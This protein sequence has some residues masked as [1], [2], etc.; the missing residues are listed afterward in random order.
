VEI[1]AGSR[2]VPGRKPVARDSNSYNNNNNSL[3]THSCAGFTAPVPI[4]KPA[5]NTTIQHK[6]SR[7][8]QKQNTKQT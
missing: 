8:T 5:K 1:T 2:E 6:N 3:G 4:I 7:N